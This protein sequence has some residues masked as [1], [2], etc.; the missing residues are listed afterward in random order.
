M[1]CV[2]TVFV[3]ALALCSAACAG[4][5]PP[6]R[7]RDD[8]PPWHPPT[9]MLQAYAG[10]DGSLT[11]AQ[12]EA[13]LKRDF[14]KADLNHDG[15]L[16]DNE[17]RLVNEARWKLDESTASPLIDFKHNGCV[18][19]D[20]FAATPRTLFEQ[21]DRDGNGKLT[22]DELKP[23]TGKAPP[24]KGDDEHRHHGG[25]GSGDSQ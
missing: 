13:G 11:R 19:F 21:L 1:G 10:P 3:V 14:D 25:E 15:C 16:E 24:D 4:Q 6:K 2:R 9:A 23:G 5:G 7:A 8:R 12:L 17:V 22:A 20:E 18:D